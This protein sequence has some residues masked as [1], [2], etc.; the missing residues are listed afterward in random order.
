MLIYVVSPDILLSNPPLLPVHP[1]IILLLLRA[2]LRPLVPALVPIHT[3]ILLKYHYHN[4][5]FAIG[6]F[7]D[8]HLQLE[9]HY[10]LALVTILVSIGSPPSL[11]LSLHPYNSSL[12]QTDSRSVPRAFPDLAQ[13]TQGCFVLPVSPILTNVPLPRQPQTTCNAQ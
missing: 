10:H 13:L 2:L 6:T 4:H 7:H 12:I 1:I 9:Y 3:T 5:N 11:P 8:P